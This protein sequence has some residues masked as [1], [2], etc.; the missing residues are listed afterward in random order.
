MHFPPEGLL[1]FLVPTI[2]LAASIPTR[3][4]IL[5]TVQHDDPQPRLPH[6]AAGEPTAFPDDREF[7]TRKANIT[8]C[9]SSPSDCRAHEI[10]I[11]PT[12][13]TLFSSDKTFSKI[14]NAL[15]SIIIPHGIRCEFFKAVDCIPRPGKERR[16]ESICNHA[17]T[18]DE[19]EYMEPI[20]PLYRI[21]E[22]EGIQCMR[23]GGLDYE[24]DGRRCYDP[25]VAD[26]WA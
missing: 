14:N 6:Y 11:N 18:E 7:L 8:L 25:A 24:S 15:S 26:K 3:S 1:L 16:L 23:C 21:E 5:F 4:N 17:H 13:P 10:I 19:E 20:P 12:K 2:A 9:P 22:G